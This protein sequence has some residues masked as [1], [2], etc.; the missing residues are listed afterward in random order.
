MTSRE[1]IRTALD[2]RQPDRVPVDFGGT[3]ET[4]IALSTVYYLRRALGLGGED[5]RVRVTDV[6]QMLGEIRDDLRDRMYI[7]TVGLFNPYNAFG[8]KNED[9]KEW[10]TF[11]G[12]R[13]LV[14]E[15][16]NTEPNENGDIYMYPQGDRSAP[17]SAV[18]PKGGFYFDSIIRQR[19]IDDG[20]LDARDN[21]E[22]FVVYSDEIL[23]YFSERSRYL[24]ENTERAVVFNFTGTSFGDVANTTAP[25]LKDPKGIRDTA[26][27]YM[28]FVTRRDYVHE[29]FAGQCEIGMENL[30]LVREAVGD[31]IDVIKITGADYG[32]QQGPLISPDWYREMIKPFHTRLCDWIHKNTSWKVFMHC[33][34]GV[35]PLIDDFIEAGFDI[36]SPVQTSAEGMEPRGLKEDFGDRLVFWGGGVDTQTTLPFGTPEEVY[37]EVTERIRIFNRGGGYVFNA[38]HNIQPRTPMENILAMIEAVRDSFRE[39]ETPGRAIP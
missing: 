26:E 33:C 5:D 36:L 21:L 25:E 7:D 14:P 38:V 29:V 2:H 10:V 17:P 37:D 28:S 24:Y 3:Y 18:M 35:R 20:D 22:E 6:Y 34:G 11:D 32:S 8:F 30:K 13:V 4:G 16:F 27:W 31:R 23:D 12:A 15:L 1:R 9:W 19:P 39:A